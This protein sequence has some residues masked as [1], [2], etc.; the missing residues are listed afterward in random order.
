M[1][2]LG[3]EKL[4]ETRIKKGLSQ[5]EIAILAN[6]DQTTYCRKENGISKITS[7]EWKRFASILDVPLKDIFECEEKSMT[8]DNVDKDKMKIDQSNYCNVPEH[9]LESL[10]KYIEKLELENKS[11]EEE[12]ITL[13]DKLKQKT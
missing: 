1:R 9:V 7:N 3:I 12:I 2:N 10:K 5:Q 4:Q 11:K 8:T 13:K 6:M